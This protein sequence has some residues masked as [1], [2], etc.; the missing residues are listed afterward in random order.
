MSIPTSR[1]S[2]KSTNL[3]ALLINEFTDTSFNC[4]GAP[5]NACLQTGAEVLYKFS[6]DNNTVQDAC[7]G[8]GMVLLGFTIGAI[9]SLYFSATSYIYMGYVGKD[10]NTSPKAQSRDSVVNL[11]N[12]TEIV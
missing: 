5:E 12:Y 10:V 8:L 7:F 6:F 4:D 11:D 9:V 1:H 3:Q 2:L